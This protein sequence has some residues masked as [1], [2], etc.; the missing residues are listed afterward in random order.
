MPYND[1][2]REEAIEDFIAAISG[3]ESNDDDTSVNESGSGCSG[4]YQFCQGT[5]DTWASA[6]GRDDLVGVDPASASGADQ[7]TVMRAKTE[8]MYDKYQGNF[9]AMADEHYAGEGAADSHYANGDYPTDA[10]SYN[11]DSYPSQSQYISEVLQ[12][13]D[14][15]SSDGESSYKPDPSMATYGGSGDV[16]EAFKFADS[17]VH[18]GTFYGENGC[19]AFVKDFLDA[20]GYDADKLSLMCPQMMQQMANAGCLTDQDS[21]GC[22][23]FLQAPNDDGA[24]HVV[25]SDGNG[26]Y[27]GNSSY[28]HQQVWHGDLSEFTGSGWTILGYGNPMGTT[29]QASDFY[30][31]GQSHSWGEGFQEPVSSITPDEYA[32]SVMVHRAREASGYGDQEEPSLFG[33]IWHDFK[34]SGNFLYKLGSALYSDLFHSDNDVYAKKPDVDNYLDYVKAAIGGNEDVARY[35]IETSRDDTQLAYAIDSYK[36]EQEEDKKYHDYYSKF[37]WHDLGYLLGAVLDPIN[38]VPMLKGATIAKGL[39]RLGVAARYVP[40]AEEAATAAERVA[41]QVANES[42]RISSSKA[43]SVGSV[44]ANTAAASMLQE[45]VTAKADGE[46]PHLASAALMGGLAGGVLRAIGLGAGKLRK[47][48]MDDTD[49]LLGVENAANRVG[50]ATRLEAMDI[51]NTYHG[52]NYEAAKKL[53]DDSFFKSSN[54][55]TAQQIAGRDDV[56]AM[57]FEDAQKIANSMGITIDKSTRGFYVPSEDFSVIIKDNAG[58]IKNLD[59][60]LTHE[61]G[62]H[63]DLKK[64]IGEDNYNDLM[65]TI[66]QEA[67]KPDSLWNEAMKKAGSSDPEEILGY[68]IENN[69]IAQPALW[70][71]KGKIL[72]AF[73]SGLDNLGFG[74][75]TKFSNRQVLNMIGESLK[76]KTGINEVVNPDGTSFIN[77][78]KFSRDNVYNPINLVKTEEME[79][80]VEDTI[81]GTSTGDKVLNALDKPI[82]QNRFTQTPMSVGLFSGSPTFAKVIGSFFEDPQMRGLSKASGISTTCERMGEEYRKTLDIGIKNM[83]SCE[84]QWLQDNKGFFTRWSPF[85]NNAARQDFRFLVQQ[86][87]CDKY[88]KNP[89]TGENIITSSVKDKSLYD[90]NVHKAADELKKMMDD[91]IEIG[92]RSGSMYGNSDANLIEAGWYPV[93]LEP[94]RV[95]N[96]DKFTK[97]ARNFVDTGD[98][99]VREYLTKYILGGEIG[100]DVNGNPIMFEGAL[101]K[102]V[103]LQMLKR[104]WELHHGGTQT[105]EEAAADRRA[106]INDT[107]KKLGTDEVP[108]EFKCSPEELD[109][110]AKEAAEDWVNRQMMQISVDKS[111]DANAGNVGDLNFFRGRLPLD[112]GKQMPLPNGQ[113][114]SFDKDLRDY[115]IIHHYTR[116]N[117]RFAGEAAMKTTLSNLGMSLDDLSKQVHG[118]LDF[119][120]TNSHKISPS[121]AER[122]GNYFDDFMNELR[123]MRPKRELMNTADVVSN[124]LNSFAYFKRGGLM[125]FSQLGDLGASIGY[126]GI[127]MIGSAFKPLAEF[128]ED[129][130][131]GKG[132]AEQIRDAN[133]FMFG[134]PMERVVFDRPV[135]D[136][137]AQASIGGSRFNDFLVNAGEFMKNMGRYTSKINMLGNMTDSMFRTARNGAMCDCIRWAHGDDFGGLRTP[138][139]KAKIDALGVP[140]DID[141]LKADIKRYIPWNGRK[142]SVAD[143]FDMEGWLKNSP[144]TYHQFRDL[145]QNQAEREVLSSHV[146]GNRNIFKDTNWMTRLACMFQDFNLRS[147]STQFM[148]ALRSRDRDD[149]M[150]AGLSL[151]TNTAAFAGR[152]AL[153]VAALSA[154]GQTEQA[155]Y[156]KDNYLNELALGR[157]AFTRSGFLSPLAMANNAYEAVSGAP[158]VRTTVTDTPRASSVNSVGDFVG[159]S[160]QQLPAIDSFDTMVRKP[161]G[162]AWAIAHDRGSQRDIRNILEATPV[163]DL[164]PLSQMMDAYANGTKYP[165][166]RPKAPKE[167]KEPFINQLLN[168]I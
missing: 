33:A 119:A 29:P 134:E 30:P 82:E 151:V 17:L 63:Q 110:V 129:C 146:K 69:M 156:I 72:D 93:D 28:A 166:K 106:A 39:A 161:V 116:T 144:I 98:D 158:T 24:C 131:A 68:A 104:D 32:E 155:Q 108:E 23:V 9:S 61:V 37:G 57:N 54:T 78:V 44:A 5:W 130:R 48:P 92:K 76:N 105:L 91:R 46:D 35:L 135:K 25:I 66:T 14:N 52:A 136:Y 154:L 70:N 165:K 53:H 160:V 1:A 120:S 112:T 123:G 71:I 40:K 109:E 2:D 141:A 4:R 142:D 41:Q 162:A 118:E 75:K 64:T 94:H 157:A 27:Y 6:A 125:G 80:S 90:A 79:K 168:N 31:Q 58:V 60:V 38:A 18:N 22:V 45:Y 147:N 56:F 99:G 113:M 36:E 89:E 138:F 55:K 133:W 124:I 43:F 143:K 88:V 103:L 8:A 81:K 117:S 152:T 74:S 67:Q 19:T 121:D 10:E 95:V 114:F 127:H 84:N 77:G 20:A 15:R 21:A 132:Q 163:P 7:Y 111:F 137:A 96:T 122:Y 140:V 51:P 50:L 83:M 59:G 62:V 100:K 34:K 3:Q 87:F 12:R 107:R 16:G 42:E 49:P 102:D 11:G 139:S 115:D 164:I 159:N 126:G 73:R 85:S 167:N 145:I 128:L 153:K 150:A 97:F 86:C 149:A 26:G 101:D 65:D 47:R 13:M 148:R